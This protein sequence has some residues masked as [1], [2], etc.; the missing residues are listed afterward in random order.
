MN[1]YGGTIT[2]GVYGGGAGDSNYFNASTTDA[3]RNGFSTVA[4]F[5]GDTHVNIYGG[6][7]GDGIYGGGAERCQRG[8][9]GNQG[10]L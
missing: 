5:Y 2:G 10:T 4:S 1:I 8:V 9:D 3:Q 6:N 7:I